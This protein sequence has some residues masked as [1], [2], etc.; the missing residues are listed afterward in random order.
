MSRRAT[1]REIAHARS[2]EKGPD[3]NISVFAYHPD[4]YYILL[5]QVTTA[6]VTRHFAGILRGEA[7]RYAV[8]SVSGLI[9]VMGDVLEGGRTRTL[10]FEESGKALSSLLLSLEIELPE[11]HPVRSAQDLLRPAPAAE[12]RDGRRKVRLG[13]ATAWARD[14]FEPAA[15]LVARGNI[16]YLCFESMSEVTMSAHQVARSA[17]PALPAFDPYLRPRL[18]PVLRQ[19]AEKGIRIISNQ[20]WLDP[21]AAAREVR[22]LAEELGLARLKIAAVDGTLDPADLI[23][24]DLTFVETG[25]PV[26][27]ERDHIVST[28]VYLGATGIVAALQMG[29]DVVIT[30]RVADACLYL[31][32]LAH[33]FGWDLSDEQAAARGMIVGHLMECGSQ[34]TGGYFSDPPYKIVPDLHRIGH[35]ICEVDSETVSITKLEDTGGIVSE[36]TCK[37]QLLYETQNPARYLGP[38]VVVDLGRVTFRQSGKDRVDVIMDNP[39]LP[40]PDTLKALVGLREG[41]IAE[42][43]VVFAGPSALQRA[44]MTE[45]L[46]RRRFDEIGLVHEE[47]R[48]DYVGLNSVHREASPPIAGEPYEVILRIAVKCADRENAGKLRREV[49]PLAVNGVSGTGKWATVSTGERIRPVI[50][51]NS[52]L[53]PR[54]VVKT[55]ITLVGSEGVEIRDL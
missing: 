17:N 11:D 36:A 7:L 5:E 9:F 3:S 24:Q 26:S 2:G 6:A 48:M 53:V 18:E 25:T 37:E 15:D 22:D 50:G 27:G 41:F 21:A 46:L 4:D 28:E 33:E 14:R 45:D 32:P 42:E 20:G 1:L 8:P 44:R 30:G 54:S 47:L 51:M 43:L 34:I 31:G 35:P 55:R 52:V 13:C 29:A 16:D 39:G 23:A 12:D 49:D 10:A 40:R 19:C 38:D